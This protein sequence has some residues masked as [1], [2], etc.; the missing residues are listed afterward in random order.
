GAWVRTPRVPSP[1][2]VHQRAEHRD[3]SRSGSQRCRPPR[4]SLPSFVILRC[5]AVLRLPAT[6][7]CAVLLALCGCGQVD[8]SRVSDAPSSAPAQPEPAAS[9]TSPSPAPATVT[10][11]SPTPHPPTH[12]PPPPPPADAAATHGPTPTHNVHCL[13][14]RIGNRLGH[15]HRR[16]RAPGACSPRSQRQPQPSHH[17]PGRRVREPGQLGFTD[18]LART[19]T[20][21]SRLR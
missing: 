5:K 8:A 18:I 10:P 20:E 1:Q 19:I 2:R 15:R 9:P 13:R 16:R 7:G 12:A 14:L 4:L 11:A 3:A 21:R 17:D 6:V